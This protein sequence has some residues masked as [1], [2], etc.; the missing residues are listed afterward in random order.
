[1]IKKFSDY[2]SL[3]EGVDVKKLSKKLENFV[4]DAV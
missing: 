1:M 3:N 4:G 2:T